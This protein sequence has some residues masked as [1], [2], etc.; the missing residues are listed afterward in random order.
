[1]TN[2]TIETNGVKTAEE[3]LS[4]AGLAW[5]AEEHELITSSGATTE[6]HKA[7]VRSDNNKIIG[8]TGKDYGVV[9]NTVAF[10]MFDIVA[11]EKGATFTDVK[12][13]DGGAR[14]VAR[15]KLPFKTSDY[16]R[17]VGDTVGRG[18]DLINS[19]D[20]STGFVGDCYAEVLACTNGMKT[21]KNEG[22]FILRHTKNVKDRYKKALEI[23]AQADR[24]F[25]EMIERARVL[26][27]KIFKAQDLK[28]FVR[29]MFPADPK[30][31]E[32]STRALNQQNI[33]ER[34]FFEGM[35]NVGR[36]AFD[37]Y[38]GLT[39]WLDH[40]RFDDDSKADKAN[41]F[42]TGRKL[43]EKAFA[44]LEDA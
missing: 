33:V 12:V 39:E 42:G 23:F 28:K 26:D 18:F 3:L 14:M 30:T 5:T 17:K 13:F 11:K 2:K 19:F 7:I 38:N 34:L 22:R 20:G 8:I 9:Q 27:G 1:M 4:N 21:R 15:M 32:F 36:S 10:S 31:K 29:A 43:R 25:D 44:Y 40:K 24:Y 41:L 6:N 35:G 16:V 37:A